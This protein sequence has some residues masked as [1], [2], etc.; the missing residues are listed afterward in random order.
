MGCLNQ[1]AIVQA[2]EKHL[3]T[4]MVHMPRG[5]ANPI[6]S[7]SE[8]GIQI[9]DTNPGIQLPL[10]YL[11]IKVKPPNLD[12][13]PHAWMTNV[14]THCTHQEGIPDIDVKIID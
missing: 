11:G 12:I 7:D 9:K 8:A 6:A 4:F 13:F 3:E 2:S 1:K 5:D 14:M 10:V